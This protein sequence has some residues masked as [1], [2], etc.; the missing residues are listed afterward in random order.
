VITLGAVSVGRAGDACPAQ[1]TEAQAALASA[2]RSEQDMRAP[3]LNEAGGLVR[4]AEAACKQGDMSIA[5]R[6]AQEALG[7]LKNVPAT[8]YPDVGAKAQPSEKMVA[9]T[10]PGDA[11][12]YQSSPNVTHDPMFIGPTGRTRTGEFGASAWIAPTAPV[13]SEMAGAGRQ[14]SGVPAIG[15]TFTWGGSSRRPEPVQA[16]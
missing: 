8:G 4:E 6:K 9:P 10:R 16:P 14:P 3:G 13:G 12:Y 15:F 5:S 1:V 11:G 7:L 2:A